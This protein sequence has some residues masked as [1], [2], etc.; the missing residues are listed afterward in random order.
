MPLRIYIQEA[1]GISP[2]TADWIIGPSWINTARYV[3]NGKPPDAVQDAMKDMT[4][5]ER[6]KEEE[7]MMQS[8]L[9]D[10]F[11]FKA[12]LETREIPVYELVQTKAGSKLNEVADPTKRWVGINIGISFEGNAPLSSLID[13][14]QCSP[15]ISGRRVVDKTNLSGVYHISL[16]WTSLRSAANPSY[17]GESVSAPGIQ[18]TS[19]FTAIE[20]QLGL[21]LVPAKDLVD[22]LVID[23]IE[24]PSPN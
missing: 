10:R 1:F 8:L 23:H 11:K 24:E 20:E 16:K 4:N 22:V 6:Q 9:A 21:K 14:L 18:G 12:H 7:M 3:F 19:L 15:D 13:A 17:S 5:D 2:N